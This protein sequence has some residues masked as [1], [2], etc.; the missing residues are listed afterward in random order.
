M[1]H[2]SYDAIVVGSGPNGLAAAIALAQ[3]KASVLVVEGSETIGGGAR[4]AELTLPGFVHDVCSAV[5]PMG[6]GSPFLRTL[7]LAEHG[8]EWVQPPITFAHPFDDGTAAAQQ[9]S[10]EE[11]A[12]TLGVDERAYRRLMGP[13]SRDADKLFGDLLGPFRLPR[14]PI[15]AF[16]FGRRAIRSG[17]GLAEA[18]FRGEPA[19]ALFAGL[20]AHA[21]LPLESRPGAAIALML[22]IAG[23]AVGWP[24]PRGGSQRIADALASY[25]RSLG[26]EIVM[27]RPVKNVDELPPAKAILCDVTPRQLVAIA[28]HRFSARYKRKLERY[29]YGPGIFKVDWALSEPIPWKNEAC[30][31]AGTVHVGGTLAEVAESERRIWEGDHPERPFVLLTQPSLFDPTRAPP[32]KHTAWGYC[33]VPN[34]STVNMTE[35]IEAQVE[36]FA[37]GFRDVILARH[38]RNTAELERYN[39]NYIGGDIGGG[40]ADLWQLFARPVLAFN[41]YA[42]TDP[43][44]YLWP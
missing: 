24:M 10:V 4:S 43:S 37:P 2:A 15:A 44:I 29:R 16:R 25:L 3:H 1:A 26:G 17:R 12:A 40:V 39:P 32:G 42:T 28:G 13:L 20:A 18:F 33:H 9:R 38:T 21:I 31:R 36:R 5:H 23:H 14:H 11:T 19:R 8:L 27:G 7:P 34:G 30:R 22:G 35:R 6:I 41:P